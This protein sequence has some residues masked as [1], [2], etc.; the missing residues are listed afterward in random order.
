MEK[1]LQL[2][3]DFLLLKNFIGKKILILLILF[4]CCNVFAKNQLTPI[5]S[6]ASIYSE[7]YPNSDS[8]FKGT[9]I[10]E[11]GSGTDLTEWKSNHSFFNCIRKMGSIFIYDRNGLGKSPADLHVDVN[12]PITAELISNKL[13]ILLQ[14]QH[15]PP[16][17]LVVAHSYGAIYSGYFILKNPNLIKGI[18]FVDPVPRDYHFSDEI[19]NKYKTGVQQAKTHSSAFIYNKYKNSEAEVIYQLLGFEKSKKSL[20]KLGNIDNS[21]PVIIVSSTDMENKK[22][23]PIKTDWFIT[24]KQWLNK[25]PASKIIQVSSSHFIQ[26]DQPKII[27]DQLK[28]LIS[29]INTNGK[30]YH[31]YTKS[32]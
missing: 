23:G 21:I 22:P 18:L 24:Q 12:N 9:I 28:L 16:P 3:E 2:M 15:I 31:A 25:N 29:D 30:E 14:K 8:K 26:I 27:C 10:F 32:K 13:S 17:Y 1:L 19:Y 4:A 5:D 20:K 6:G 11:N 7:Y